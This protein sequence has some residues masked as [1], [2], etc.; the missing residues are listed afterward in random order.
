ML[1]Y[2]AL[3][4]PVSTT[5]LTNGNV[6]DVSAMFV[7]NITLRKPYNHTHR[8]HD[9]FISTVL[10]GGLGANTLCCCEVGRA[11]NKLHTLSLRQSNRMNMTNNGV[12]REWTYQLAT[13]CYT[14]LVFSDSFQSL[15][16]QSRTPVYHYSNSIRASPSPTATD[17]NTLFD[18]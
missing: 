8:S 18:V 1:T 16:D 12:G 14:S 2:L 3:T 10:T 13:H 5:I 17:S 4:T 7:D 6:I 15:P 11:A 9:Q